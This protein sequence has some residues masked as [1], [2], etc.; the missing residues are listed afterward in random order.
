MEGMT[1]KVSLLFESPFLK[2]EKTDWYLITC[3]VVKFKQQTTAFAGTVFEK[4]GGS[5]GQP[6][7]GLLRN[8]W[9]DK[10]EM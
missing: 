4:Y 6:L 2:T 3:R 7:T 9:R 1:S 10:I 8:S 5:A